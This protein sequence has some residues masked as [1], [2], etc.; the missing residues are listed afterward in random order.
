MV[1]SCE[2]MECKEN[3]KC[4]DGKCLLKTCQ[5]QE[6]FGCEEGECNGTLLSSLDE[7]YC[8]SSP[9]GNGGYDLSVSGPV[10]LEGHDEENS[11]GGNYL[12][13]TITNTDQE[14]G[15]L[16]V[17]YKVTVGSEVVI[18]HFEIIDSGTARY[19]T[20]Y[21]LPQ[22]LDKKVTFILDPNNE[23]D[24]EESEENNSVERQFGFA[25]KDLY[26]KDAY[27]SSE[28]GGYLV[29]EI[30]MG[31]SNNDCPKV[32]SDLYIDGEKYS[33]MLCDGAGSVCVTGYNESGEHEIRVVVDPQ[34]KVEETNESNN[35]FTRTV[36]GS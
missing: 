31:Q 3:E 5:E 22:V 33:N 36:T 6:G 19:R 12:Y 20:L 30:E 32:E 11:C 15:W 10:T 8:C 2:G 17:D 27:Y 14:Y 28:L 29:Y 21:A 35:E 18:D 7:E 26:G 9:C 1:H 24:D 16:N 34:N 23:Y 13:V 25:K 4:I